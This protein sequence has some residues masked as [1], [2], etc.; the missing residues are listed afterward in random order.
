MDHPHI[1]Q[2]DHPA[3]KEQQ[4]CR[5]QTGTED[6][7]VLQRSFLKTYGKKGQAHMVWG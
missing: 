7:S 1:H 4:H 3:A 6:L 5:H 2:V